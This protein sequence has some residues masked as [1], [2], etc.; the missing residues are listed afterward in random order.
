[1][2]LP[3]ESKLEPVI[4][5]EHFDAIAKDPEWQKHELDRCAAE[6]WYAIVN[7]CWTWRPDEAAGGLETVVERVPPER[8]LQVIAHDWFTHPKYILSKSRQLLATW[9][10]MILLLHRC[11]FSSNIKAFCQT[12]KEDDADAEMIQRARF[13]YDSLP[14]W[15]RKGNPGKYSYC[16]M[17]FPATGSL[18][19]GIPAGGDQIRSHNP[20]ILVSDEFAFQNDAEESYT[21]ALACCKRIT[22]VSSANPGFMRDLV[23]DKIR[24]GL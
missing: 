7:Y 15:M 17:I 21:A 11:L 24:P 16:K 8:Y 5:G 4:F 10:M 6:P 22:L 19:R 2:I 14:G 20:N 13:V 23:K 12:K 9:L 3:A 1:L 18:M